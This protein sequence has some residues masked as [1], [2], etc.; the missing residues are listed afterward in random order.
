[1]HVVAT[2]CWYSVHIIIYYTYRLLYESVKYVSVYTQ[3]CAHIHVVLHFLLRGRFVLFAYLFQRIEISILKCKQVCL[4]FD[5]MHI[6][7][8]RSL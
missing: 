4:P 7:D 2:C 1:M 6:F 3:G 8:A 5:S